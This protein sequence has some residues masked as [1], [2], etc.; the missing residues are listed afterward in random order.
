MLKGH[1]TIELTNVHTGKKEVV[2]HDNLITNVVSDH[3]NRFAPLMSVDTY[4]SNFTPLYNAAMGGILLFEN[5]LNVDVNNIAFPFD[6]GLTGYASNDANNT[7][8]TKRG[9][10]NLTESAKLSNGYKYVWDFTTSQANGP[11][12]A[13]ALT[14]KYGG[15]NPYSDPYYILSKPMSTSGNFLI[16]YDFETDVFHMYKSHY[17]DGIY[18]LYIREYMYIRNNISI[19]DVFNNLQPLFEK[20]VTGIPN[21]ITKNL[22]RPIVSSKYQSYYYVLYS[23]YDSSISDYGKYLFRVDADTL[24]YDDSF[25][26]KLL[27]KLQE[28]YVESS[29]NTVIYNGYLYCITRTGD[30]TYTLDEISLSDFSVNLIDIPGTTNYNFLTLYSPGVLLFTNYAYFID[31]NTFVK[32]SIKSPDNGELFFSDK[33]YAVGMYNNSIKH[34]ELTNYLASINNLDAPVT[35]TA[36]KTMKIIYTVTEV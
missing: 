5:Q 4:A 33:G 36:D 19:T 7:T 27:Y 6:N 12:S 25:G 29:Y 21:D 18:T 9:S 17:S 28:S 20:A 24:K 30:S 11:I 1:A 34:Y 16:D 22:G 31:S 3:M 10:R 8:D 2:E 32:T 15:A 14:S 13:L 26:K 35:K 23:A